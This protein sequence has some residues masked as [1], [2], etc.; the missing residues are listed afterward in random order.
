MQEIQGP[1]ICELSNSALKGS[2]PLPKEINVSK[3]RPEMGVYIM[4]R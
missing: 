3:Q 1:E 4:P 2:N